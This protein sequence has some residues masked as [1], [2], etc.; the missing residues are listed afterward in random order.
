LLF[1][2]IH[3]DVLQIDERVSAVRQVDTTT[4][5]DTITPAAIVAK[6]V[7][8]TA[9]TI[10]IVLS[11]ILAFVVV[12]AVLGLL[13]IIVVCFNYYKVP[14]SICANGSVIDT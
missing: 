12:L 8:V 13:F 1:I 2:Y 14:S 9:S 7:T 10:A 3:C 6:E 5:T 4:T 11:I